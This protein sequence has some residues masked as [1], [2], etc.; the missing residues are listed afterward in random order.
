[1][2]IKGICGSHPRHI[3]FFNQLAKEHDVVCEMYDK[4]K[5][6]M[7]VDMSL[8]VRAHFEKVWK[9]EN[10]Y[11]GSDPEKEFYVSESPRKIYGDITIVFGSD[12]LEVKENTYN[13]HL[14]IS[15]RYRGSATLFWA[16]YMYQPEY[17]GYTFHQISD[18]PDEGD[19]VHQSVPFVVSNY[20][21][22]CCNVVYEAS[23]DILKLLQTKED[24][25]LHKQPEIGKTWLSTDFSDFHLRN[26]EPNQKRG[27][28]C[29][30]LI[31]QW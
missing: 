27:K 28:K 20:Y 10:Y 8:P 17:A 15:P 25:K 18:K 1:M 13:L 5:R 19:I 16:Y 26:F 23:R 3:W 22:H 21:D 12:M 6:E 14:G 11:F 31:K 2:Q 29:Q 4:G 30:N 24:W 7:E 9:A